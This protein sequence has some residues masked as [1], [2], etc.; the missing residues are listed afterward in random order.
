MRSKMIKKTSVQEW[1][2]KSVD[3]KNVEI[4]IF[5]R[6]NKMRMKVVESNTI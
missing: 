1:Q 4:V 3:W 6:L 2:L 5:V